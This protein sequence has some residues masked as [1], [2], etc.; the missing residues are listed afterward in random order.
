LRP[1]S[2]LCADTLQQRRAQ[3][4]GKIE[5]GVAEALRAIKL[6]RGARGGRKPLIFRHYLI[7]NLAKIWTGLERPASA[8][9]KSDFVTFC[10]TVANL[11]GWPIEGLDSAI[12][13][14]L[15]DF[16]LA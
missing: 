2:D 15:K 5:S 14:A 3:R 9:P 7:V 4:S 13:D 12:P 1:A 11:I 6:Q 8:G 10:V 16:N